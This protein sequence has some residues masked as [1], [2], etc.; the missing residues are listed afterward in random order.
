MKI[1]ISLIKADIGSIGGHIKPSQQVLD[2]VINFIKASPLII[3]S[4]IFHTGDDIAILMSHTKGIESD[5][6]HKLAWDALMAGTQ[7]A[8]QQGLYGAGQDLLKDS[9]SGNV[10]GAGP[11]VAELEFDERPAEPFLVFLADF[12]FDF[13]VSLGCLEYIKDIG[14]VVKEFSRITSKGGIVISSF[15][16]KKN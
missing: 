14:D 3:D 5:E 13:V 9:F 15:A 8:K 10:K 1:T 7:I 12:S 2:T 6:I 4:H 16:N 11:A